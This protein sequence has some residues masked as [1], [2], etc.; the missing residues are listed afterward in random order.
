MKR[1]VDLVNFNADASCLSCETWLSALDGGAES[2]LCRWLG[3]YVTLEKRVT[4]GFTGSSLAD[5]RF[6]N[7]EAIELVK[8]HPEMFEIIARPFAHDI[9]LLRSRAGFLRN[10]ELGLKAVRS[11]FSEVPPF[12]LPSE[13]M[14]TNEQVALLS[15]HEIEAV[16]VNASRLHNDLACRLP[17]H[18]YPIQGIDDTSLCCWPVHGDLTRAY[19]DSIHLFDSTPW[20][21]ALRSFSDDRAVLWRDGETVLLFPNGIQ[22]EQIWLEGEDD[23][24]RV[25]LRDER[26]TSRPD[27]PFQTYPVHSFGDWMREF[28]MVGYIMRLHRLEEDVG[29]FNI[30]ELTLWLGAVN[31]DVLSAVEKH[32]VKVALR[33]A[34]KDKVEQTHVLHRSERGFEG[35][36]MLTLLELLRRDGSDCAAFNRF[37]ASDKPH[38]R[39]F[40]ARRKALSEWSHFD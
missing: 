17:T 35:E 27:S 2:D 32:S 31:S 23:I 6:F 38:A 1:L 22:R 28:R 40:I 12:F 3:L 20:A 34:R 26:T 33:P 8:A 24:E 7:P 30:D 36:E 37:T 5:I 13:F 11:L 15:Q 10:L 18:P 4:L 39:K 21:N 29:K 16:A 25:H 14:L 9:A 19:L